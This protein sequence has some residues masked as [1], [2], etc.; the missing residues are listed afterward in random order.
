MN[1]DI[2]FQFNFFEEEAQSENTNKYTVKTD[3][4][5]YQIHPD[6]YVDI[7]NLVD[8]NKY[9]QLCKNIEKSNISDEEKRFLKFAATR[10]IVFN[11]NLIAEYYARASKETQ[12]LMEESALVIIDYDNAIMYGYTMLANEIEKLFLEDYET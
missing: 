3:I 5:Q 11:Y 2:Q 9:K 4:P 7:N 6:V 10:H 8:F 12:Q 1:K